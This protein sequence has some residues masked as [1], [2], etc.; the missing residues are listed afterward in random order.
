MRSL[1]KTPVAQLLWVVCILA[2]LV[3]IAGYPF[4]GLGVMVVALVAATALRV[5]GVR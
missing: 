5:L 2:V 3:M 4:V 1:P